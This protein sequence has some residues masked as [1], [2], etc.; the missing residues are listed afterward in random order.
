MGA[1]HGKYQGLIV[2]AGNGNPR[3]TSRATRAVGKHGGGTVYELSPV[4]M[5]VVV[6]REDVNDQGSHALE[7]GASN[8]VKVEVKIVSWAVA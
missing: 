6:G 5:A 7:H 1:R 8:V 3:R 2:L 4:M